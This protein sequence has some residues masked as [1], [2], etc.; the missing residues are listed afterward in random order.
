MFDVSNEMLKEF[1]DRAMYDFFSISQGVLYKGFISMYLFYTFICVGV[2]SLYIAHT[3]IEM[4]SNM[5]FDVRT[6]EEMIRND[7]ENEINEL[8]NKCKI[9]TIE[10]IY[11]K[12]NTIYYLCTDLR[13][14]MYPNENTYYNTNNN[15]TDSDSNSDTD[16]NN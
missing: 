15:N 4:I 9:M 7:I 16:N 6:Q 14:V 5:T 10:G 1:M 11:N 2:V 12:V 13:N 8:N 3:I